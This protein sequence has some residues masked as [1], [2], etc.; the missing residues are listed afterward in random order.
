MATRWR[1]RLAFAAL[2]LLLVFGVRGLLSGISLGSEYLKNDYFRTRQFANQ[3]QQ[4]TQ[5]LSMFELNYLDNEEMKKR[6]TVSAEEID[7]YRTRYGDLSHQVDSI[8]AQ[9]EGK[10]Q[11]AKEKGN[12]EVAA[13]YTYE[14]DQKIK[15]ITNNFT[16]DDYVKDKIV[17]E[18][19]AKI[20]KYFLELEKMRPDYA[21][22]Q[23][24]FKYYL[25]DITTGEVFTNLDGN[26]E[27]EAEAILNYE[28]MLS[29][30]TYPSTDSGYLTATDDR[31]LP[32]LE[33]SVRPVE[34]TMAGKIGV[35]KTV[36]ATGLVL[37]SYQDYQQK[38]TYYWFFT[39]CSL[40]AL[41]VSAY[42]YRKRP[43]I[44]L[45]EEENWPSF[46]SRI[47]LDLASVGLAATALITLILVTNTIPLHIY[48]NIENIVFDLIFEVIMTALFLALTIIQGRLLADRV[49]DWPSFQAEWRKGIICRSY[50]GVLDLFLVRRFGTQV[51]LALATAFAFGGG[52]V[53]V[54]VEP[55]AILLYGPLFL[56]IGLPMMI[57]VVKWTGYFN[58]ILLNTGEIVRGNLEPDLPAQGKSALATLAANINTL[59]YGV[60]A[61]QREQIKS[62]RLKTELIT[63]VSHDLRTPLTSIISYTELLKAPELAQEDREAYVQIIDRKAK[64]LKVLID[65]LFEASKMA[66]G[67]IELVK[68]K[69]DL[70]QLLQQALAEHNETITESSLQFRV[71]KPEKPVYAVVDGP[72]L[73][74]VFDNLIGNILK[75][76]L[77]NTR[78]YINLQVLED[79]AAIVFKNIAKFELGQ[80]GEELFERFKRGDASRHTEG[81]GLGLAIA[82]S[83]VDLHG[84][85]LDIEVDGDLFKITVTLNNVL[86]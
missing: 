26:S 51:L 46:Y 83:I 35:P 12:L 32:D 19:E 57:A 47:P 45:L 56:L 27:S 36:S 8:N 53:I 79:K 49:K 66:S 24:D 7:E 3:L 15:D 41:G 64:R 5:Y 48:R 72:K 13:L 11:I 20:D 59:K 71:T 4:F 16:S 75:Y 65:D 29:I 44:Q 63:N 21:R 50:R 85:S 14:R 68:E 28:N 39:I 23:P 54:I 31:N 40:A 62:E 69:V 82:K 43:I 70:V 2:M 37:L 76:S 9:Y 1:N 30:W 86:A 17:K 61:S 84:G 52:A 42:L 34:R 58:R 80:D 38:R 10:I 67:N 6:I 60:K 25:K 33:Q 77:E 73:W 55:E 22:L 18:K 74:R 78:V 81:S